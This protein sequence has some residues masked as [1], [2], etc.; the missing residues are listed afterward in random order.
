MRNLKEKVW[1][2]YNN[3]PREFEITSIKSV[4]KVYYSGDLEPKYII[5]YG[6][7]YSPEKLREFKSCLSFPNLRGYDLE[8]SD[9]YVEDVKCFS[10]KEELINSLYNIK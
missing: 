1:V 10:T 9:I 5:S 4:K 3:E 8:D 7:G 6:L 2:M